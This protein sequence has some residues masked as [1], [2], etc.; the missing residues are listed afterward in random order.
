M[1]I[2]KTIFFL[3]VSTI[4]LISANESISL[5]NQKQT[6]YLYSDNNVRY[7]N[8]ESTL[9]QFHINFEV[10]DTFNEENSLYIIP[11][12]YNID[13]EQLPKYYIAYQTLDLEKNLLT[14]SY[15]L[16]LANA[17][18]VWDYSRHNIDLYKS[19]IYNYYYLP[20]NY[21]HADPVILPCFL[22]ISALDTYKALLIYSNHD[23]TEISSLIPVL[24]FH[25]FI[26][27]PKLIVEAGV[28]LGY[29]TQ[30]F[31]QVNRLTHSLLIGIDNDPNAIPAYSNIYNGTFALIND[32]DFPEYYRKSDFKD[33]PIDIVFIDTSH[34]YTHTLAE[35]Q[36]FVPLLSANGIIMFHDSY[37][38][39]LIVDGRRAFWRLNN[40]IQLACEN[41]FGVAPAIKDYFG[42]SFDE[43]AY[44]NKIFTR[45]GLSWHMIHY[46]F[47]N[48]LTILKKI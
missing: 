37:V 25:S 2:K 20:N 28:C 35:I 12:I 10:T 32:L 39:P 15:L 9:R 33:T 23:D 21:E 45:D 1:Q 36:Q 18:A 3:Y 22:P 11:N 30:S 44:T 34:E 41:P 29:S 7:K 46:P 4:S 26:Q 27:N 47:C 16:K 8:L 43:S 14:E 38:T 17:V 31:Q 19:Q 13:Q 48:G 42:I 40:T 6:I 24:F 5:Y